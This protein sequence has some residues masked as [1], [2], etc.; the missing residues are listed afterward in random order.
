M[1]R[2]I[3]LH[4]ENVAPAEREETRRIEYRENVRKHSHRL[5][6]I[7]ASHQA[8]FWDLASLDRAAMLLEWPRKD[9]G[10]QR[11]LPWSYGSCETERHHQDN[12]TDHQDRD[13]AH[14]THQ[15]RRAY[16]VRR[17]L[18]ALC[19]VGYEVFHTTVSPRRR[20]QIYPA[21]LGDAR[22]PRPP[23]VRRHAE[24]GE[25]DRGERDAGKKVMLRVFDITGSGSTG[26]LSKS[27]QPKGCGLWWR[28]SAIARVI[29]AVTVRSATS[30][31]RMTGAA[32][33]P[34]GHASNHPASPPGSP[35]SPRPVPARPHPRPPPRP[36]RASLAIR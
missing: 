8:V 33:G 10:H 24:A 6:D 31:N 19:R 27:R 4:P 30:P 3:P 2:T 9:I 29:T 35:G 1:L 11:P 21:R 14:S 28:L 13:H 12:A 25:V 32:F 18:S 23:A 22:D 36:W 7:R 26:W 34:P 5:G 16:E 20:A 15:V 17:A